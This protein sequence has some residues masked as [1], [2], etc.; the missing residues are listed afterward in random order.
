MH[1]T[2]DPDATDGPGLDIGQPERAPVPVGPG[3]AGKKPAGCPLWL[4]VLLALIALLLLVALV[5][6]A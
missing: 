4:C 6:M 2:W 3:A 5:L 1:V